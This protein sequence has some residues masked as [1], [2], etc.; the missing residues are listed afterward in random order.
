M[1]T[2][3][4]LNLLAKRS[5]QLFF[6]F[7]ASN[8]RLVFSNPAFNDFFALEKGTDTYHALLNRVHPEDK[9]YITS[10]VADCLSGKT[11]KNIE[12]RFVRGKNERWLRITPYLYND[13]KERLVFGDAEDIHAYKILSDVLN[14]HNEKKNAILTILSHDLAGPLS[15]IKT[16]THL[17]GN[18]TRS[19]AA[20]KIAAHIDSINNLSESCI[21]LIHDFIN[22]EFLESAATS[23]VKRRTD[24]VA[25]LDGI[26]Q[27]FS[28]QQENLKLHFKF[29]AKEKVVYAEVD[30]DKFIQVINNLLSNAIK[31]TADGGTITLSIEETD[32]NFLLSVADTGIG[33]PKQ[34]QEALFE[35]FS[36]ARRSGLKGE[37]S[38]GLGMYLIKTIVAWHQGE[39]Y[40]E[41][42]EQKGTTF[43]IKL[44]K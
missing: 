1:M 40:F 35:R 32:Q 33:I 23:L 22:Q 2:S 15:S 4:I 38:T 9:A 5:G 24:L 17:I 37:P 10:K 7:D 34:Y 42:E 36:A 41:S 39:I 19:L 3:Q 6:C 16:F 14:S 12:C 28:R 25:K 44:P 18:E 21:H 13:T 26:M 8:G 11:L 30:E 20:T 27:Q 31:F 29:E 43:Y